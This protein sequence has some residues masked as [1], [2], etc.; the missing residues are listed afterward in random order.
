MNNKD[1]NPCPHGPDILV[2]VTGICQAGIAAMTCGTFNEREKNFTDRSPL[3]QHLFP[4]TTLREV[5]IQ[6]EEGQ[7]HRPEAGMRLAC[8]RSTV[9]PGG[10]GTASCGEGRDEIRDHTDQKATGLY[11]PGEL[12]RRGGTQSQLVF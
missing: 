8:G 2:G 12:P 7:V 1:K 10:A 6:V 11:Q 5:R 4:G 3:R 9:E